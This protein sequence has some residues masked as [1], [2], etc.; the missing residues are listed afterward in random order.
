M[1][2]LRSYVIACGESSKLSVSPYIVG[3]DIVTEATDWPWIVP[4]FY[5]GE[6][7]GAGVHI[8]EGWI[9]TAGHLVRVQR[10]N[11]NGVR[12]IER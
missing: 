4:I 2:S 11:E 12:F 7:Q 6:L 10:L 3:G 1:T 5:G 8:G 9:V